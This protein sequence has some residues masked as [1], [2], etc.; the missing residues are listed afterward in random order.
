VSSFIQFVQHVSWNQ[1]APMMNRIEEFFYFKEGNPEID[2]STHAFNSSVIPVP[3][4]DSEQ[5]HRQS[6]GK[7]LLAIQ[8]AVNSGEDGS[9]V[10]GKISENETY[11][12]DYDAQ[13]GQYGDLVSKGIIDP[14]KVVRTALQDAASI[15]GLL[16]TTEAMAQKSPRRRRM[17]LH[18]FPPP[19]SQLQFP[20]LQF[21]IVPS[22]LFATHV[23]ALRRHR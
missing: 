13:E 17:H 7:S 9:I 6:S 19:H 16:M 8:I 18:P 21:A 12:F 11:A 20:A 23:Y 1:Y 3:M 5:K 10:V 14:T 15:A 4:P 22:P 2:T